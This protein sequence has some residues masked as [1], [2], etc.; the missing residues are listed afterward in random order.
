MIRSGL[1]VGGRTSYLGKLAEEIC[2]EDA[3]LF[4]AV[5]LDDVR[6]IFENET[7]ELVILGHETDPEYRVQLL[8]YVLDVSP[9]SSIHLMGAGSDPLLFLSKLLPCCGID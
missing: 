6:R 5:S 8:R 4:I 7:I 1:L 2:T 3:S 9:G